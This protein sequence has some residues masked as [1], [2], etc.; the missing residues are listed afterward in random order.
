MQQFNNMKLFFV[1]VNVFLKQ[2][3]GQKLE[4]LIGKL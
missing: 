2:I 3:Y 1:V 4:V